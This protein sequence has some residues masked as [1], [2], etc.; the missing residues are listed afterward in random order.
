MIKDILTNIDMKI[1]A[2]L[3]LE[4]DHAF[5]AAQVHRTRT[6]MEA[7]VLNDIKFPTPASKY[8]QALR[9][10]DVMSQGVQSLFFD[11]KENNI[12]IKMLDRKIF[13]EQDD[14]KKELLI[15]KK[16]RKEATARS[17]RRIARNKVREIREWSDIKQREA[18]KMSKTELANVDNHQLISYTTRWINQMM[19]KGES[20]SQS[21]QINL[22][23]QLKKGL[24]LC[25]ANGVIDIVMESISDEARTHILL[26]SGGKNG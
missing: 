18:K 11:Y 3:S 21:E 23:S 17:I 9:E 7:S 26:I 15:V 4:L 6:E 8:W 14:L 10:Q 1:L 12:R 25:E 16:D 24:S 20:T 5:S 22:V 19:V 13:K 2:E